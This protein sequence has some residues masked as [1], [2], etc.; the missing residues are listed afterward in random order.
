MW[1]GNVSYSAG[2]DRRARDFGVGLGGLGVGVIVGVGVGL[3]VG[4]GVGDEVGVGVA[5]SVQAARVSSRDS[6]A[7]PAMSRAE[8]F[9]RDIPTHP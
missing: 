3:T 6:V 1:E 4:T 7:R 8:C 5:T 9:W 2:G